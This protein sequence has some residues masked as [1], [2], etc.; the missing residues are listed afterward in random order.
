METQRRKISKGYNKVHTVP[1]FGAYM[2][3]YFLPESISLRQLISVRKE[4][5]DSSW[6]VK[7]F[8]MISVVH[9]WTKN[10]K[11]ASNV[12]ATGCC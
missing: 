1:T 4:L 11:H 3:Y 2:Q 6:I 8:F 7:Q 12:M 9:K 10:D 5:D